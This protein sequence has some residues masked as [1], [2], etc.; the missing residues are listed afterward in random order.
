GDKKRTHEIFGEF[1]DRYTIRQAEADGATLPILYEGRT[2][3]GVVAEGRNLDDVFEDMFGEL[4]AEELER[5]KQKYATTGHVLEAE[6]LIAAKAR[7]MLRHY[8]ATIL[9][10]GFKAQVVA[11]S[12]LATVRYHAA[13]MEARAE[14]VTAIEALDPLE[15]AAGEEKLEGFDDERRFLIRASRY[16]KIIRELEFAPIIS[17]SQ[18]DDA[19]WL[20]WTDT[21]KIAL[22]IGRFKLPLFHEEPKKRDPL[23]FLIVKSMLLT[24]F[25]A[26]IV[27]AMYLDRPIKEAELLQA[28]ARVNRTYPKKTAGLVVDYYG[29]ARH[30][31]EALAAYSA[32]D[33]EGALQSLKDEIP[34]LR[35]RH[36]RVITVFT[37][38][39]I[40]DLSDIE[41]CAG[42]LRDDRVRAEFQVLL[43]RFLETLDLVLPRPEALPYVESARRFGQIQNRAGKFGTTDELVLGKDIGAKVRKLI[44]DHL[45]SVGIDQSIPPVSILDAH[46]DEEIGRHRNDRAKASDMEHALRYHIRKNFDEDPAHYQKLSERLDHILETQKGRW[47]DLYEALRELVEREREGHERESPFLGVLREEMGLAE[48]SVQRR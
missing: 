17:G 32:D 7:D 45:I 11:S 16:L 8:V 5:I 36:H 38:R 2:A 1:I 26:P 42:L 12:R 18:N 46:F 4:S 34:K 27:Q 14:L 48:L 20:T 35:D 9:P 28:I 3:E 15:L 6:K 39:G 44:D 22:R 41:A 31:K 13:F 47:E 19:D 37:S 21:N 10:N 33:I 24:G 43:K 25:D 29:V 23:A 30:L 40:E